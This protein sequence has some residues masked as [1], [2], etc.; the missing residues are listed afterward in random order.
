M[1]KTDIKDYKDKWYAFDNELST[2]GNVKDNINKLRKEVLRVQTVITEAVNDVLH[3]SAT[4]TAKRKYYA[5]FAKAGRCKDYDLIGDLLNMSWCDRIRG[6]LRGTYD[7]IVTLNDI[8][9][10]RLVLNFNDGER[11]LVMSYS[12]MTRIC[13]KNRYFDYTILSDNLS[14]LDNHNT[15]KSLEEYCLPLLDEIKSIYNDEVGIDGEELATSLY[16]PI[17][18]G[19]SKDI[20]LRMRVLIAL[21]DAYL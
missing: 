1:T 18:K 13:R 15:Y 7:E 4:G 10:T 19:I 6:R 14:N 8:S 16:S 12:G 9:D 21:Y 3:F 11:H 20:L 5:N 17:I 2:G